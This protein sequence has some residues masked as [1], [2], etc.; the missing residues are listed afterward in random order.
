MIKQ[1]FRFDR[2]NVT[3]WEL[4]GLT[5]KW[6]WVSRR[7]AVYFGRR[8][9]IVKRG[10]PTEVWLERARQMQVENERQDSV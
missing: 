8:R 3:Y 9:Y 4:P 5:V 10:L 6:G 1:R 2:G 7:L